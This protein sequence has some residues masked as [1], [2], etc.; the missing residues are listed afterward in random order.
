M[1]ALAEPVTAAAGGVVWRPCEDGGLEVAVA[2]RPRYDDW[3]LPKGKL[4]RG[5]HALTAAVREVGEETGLRVVVGRRSLRTCYPVADGLK[6]VDYW[7]MQA[8]GGAFEANDE[9][10]DLRW[11]TPEQATDRCTYEHDRA[12]IADLVR[13]DVPRMPT[14]LLVRH[15]HAGSRRDW[16]GPDDLRPLE[17]RGRREAARLAA[18][19]PAFAPTAVL[20]APPTRCQETVTPL[21]ERLGLP[22]QP[23]PEL[24]EQEFSADPQAGLAAVERLLAPRSGPGVT[25]VCS[26]GGAIPSVLLALGVRWEGVPARLHPPAAKGSVWVLGGRPGALSA[27]Y[28][29]DFDADPAAP[30]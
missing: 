19:L 21:A 8:V 18:V 20:S 12:V 4:D 24:G 28:H 6:Q 13:A 26:Q 10:D 25:V 7:V 2:H 11:L 3:S 16:D 17:G 1:S 27:D 9:V 14:L 30:A 22:V 15:A 23:L 5:E 29:R